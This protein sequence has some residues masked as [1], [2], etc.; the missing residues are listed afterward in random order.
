MAKT[1]TRTKV[2]SINKI[3]DKRKKELKIKDFTNLDLEGLDLSVI[4]AP[5]WNGCIFKNTSVKNTGI[6]LMLMS[7]DS[8]EY[9]SYLA[10]NGE[11]YSES[12][13]CDCDFSENNL[14]PYNDDVRF[15]YFRNCNFRNTNLNQFIHGQNNL[16]DESCIFYKSTYYEPILD[17]KTIENNPQLQLEKKHIVSTIQSLVND[18]Y[19]DTPYSILRK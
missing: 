18:Q 15:T 13:I 14:A 8:R 10:V 16:L 5:S 6:K 9:F 19:I 7:L 3:W 12:I 17:A 1:K 4:P 11:K 2:K